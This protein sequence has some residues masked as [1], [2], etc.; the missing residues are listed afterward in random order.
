MVVRLIDWCARNR[1]LVLLAAIGL[2]GW[3]AWTMLH[4]PLDAVPDISDVQVIVATEWMGRSPDL[5]EDQVTYPLVTALLSTPRVKAVRGFT[6]FGISYVY[7]VFDDGTDMY[8]ARSRVVEYL[9]GLRGQLPEGAN[10]VIGPDATGVGWVFEYAL[11]DETGEHNLADLRSFQDWHLRYWLAS[12]PGVAE[13]ASIGGFVKQYQVNV[14][15]NKLVAF[16]I[17]IKDVIQAIKLS[18]NDVEGRLLEFSG[19]EYMVRG[20]GYLTSIADIEGVS[21][22]AGTGG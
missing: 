7:V 8:W 5:V 4:T 3:G 19:R 6:D 18:N 2:S 10:P 1:A 21:L 16:G 17:G 20:R 11:V 13:V 14:D 22:G 12:V 9:Q 15:P